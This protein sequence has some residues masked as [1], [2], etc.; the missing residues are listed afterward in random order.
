MNEL[1][2]FISIIIVFSFLLATYYKFGKVSLFAY[3]AFA[4][5]FANIIVIKCVNLFTLS[6][7]LGNVLFGGISLATDILNENYGEKEARKSVSISFCILILFTILSQIV[8][9]FIP[10]ST[11]IAQNALYQVFSLSP[12]ICIGSIFAYFIS[13]NLNIYCFDKI[14]EKLPENKF[15]WI[16]NNA[17]TILSQLIDSTIFTTCAFSYVFETNTLISIIFTTWII[18]VIIALLDTPFIYLSKNIAKKLTK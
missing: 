5:V 4:T 2:F 17:S 8:L 15:L 18:K 6:V 1:L 3:I 16:R 13:T 12:R 11:D 7:T 9:M 14:K 10:N